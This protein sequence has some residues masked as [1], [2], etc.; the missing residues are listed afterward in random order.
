MAANVRVF[1]R[2][3]FHWKE[4]SERPLQRVEEI[5]FSPQIRYSP[6]PQW[7]FAFGFRSFA[8]KKFSY[9][10]NIRQFEST[11]I[12]AGPTAGIVIRMSPVSTIEVRGWKEFQHQSGGTIR[13]YSNMTMNVRYYF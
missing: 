10:N 7:Y 3:E 5:T 9:M 2:G 8:Q 4:F 11:F 1:E 13:E 12:S 6:A